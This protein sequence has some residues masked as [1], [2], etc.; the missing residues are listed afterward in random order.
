MMALGILI[1]IIV[2]WTVG[3]RTLIAF[4]ELFRWFALFAFAGNLLPR[5][6][7]AKRFAMDHL[8]W[9]WFNLLAV[10]PLTLCCCLLLNFLLHGPEERML[11]QQGRSFD[12]QGYWR[13][14][15]SLPPHL[16]WPSNF[17]ADPEKDRLALSTANPGDKVYAL[18]EGCLG[19]LVVTEATLIRERQPATP[20]N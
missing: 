19:Y 18:A 13:E 9:F 5:R 6:W 1:F 11:V 17:G 4:T 8:E 16:P 7:Y 2:F 14:E 10:G 3:Q 20:D 12:L 15:R